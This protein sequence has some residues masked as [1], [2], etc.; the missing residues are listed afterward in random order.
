M[1]FTKIRLPKTE[2]GARSFMELVRRH[3]VVASRGHGEIVYEVPTT[4]L[5]VLAALK[6]PY[7]VVEDSLAAAQGRSGPQ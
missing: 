1:A 4:A 3:R 6:L 7:E 2:Q 5:E